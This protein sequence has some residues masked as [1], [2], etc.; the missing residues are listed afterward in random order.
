MPATA[1]PLRAKKEPKQ[2]SAKATSA[3]PRDG[4]SKMFYLDDD[5]EASLQSYMDSMGALRPTQTAVFSEGLRMFLA[6]KGFWPPKR[7]TS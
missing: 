5:L 6:A 2:P 7:A 1:T 3:T 4:T